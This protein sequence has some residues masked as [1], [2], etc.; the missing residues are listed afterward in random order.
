[1]S[2]SDKPLERLHALIGNTGA[3][4]PNDAQDLKV[5]W[6]NWGN[7]NNQNTRIEAESMAVPRSDRD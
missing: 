5:D 2:T 4:Q 6:D 1:M 7:W 3:A